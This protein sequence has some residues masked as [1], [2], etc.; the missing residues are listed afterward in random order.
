MHGSMSHL[1]WRWSA[2]A[3]KKVPNA[4][5][6]LVARLADAVET[7]SIRIREVPHL[8]AGVFGGRNLKTWFERHYNVRVSDHLGCDRLGILAGEIKADFGKHR[9]H[10]HVQ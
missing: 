4:H 10:V 7:L 6:D 8:D 1:R 5:P 9:D 2:H 3:I